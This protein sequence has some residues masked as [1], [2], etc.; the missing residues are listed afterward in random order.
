MRSIMAYIMAGL[1]YLSGGLLMAAWFY[2]MTVLI[3]CLD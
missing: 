3:F 2:A 1:Y